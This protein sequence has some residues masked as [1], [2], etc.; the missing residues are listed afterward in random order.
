MNG[1]ARPRIG[2]KLTYVKATPHI[3]NA[4]EASPPPFGAPGGPR[5]QKRAWA[6]FWAL[7]PSLHYWAIWVHSDRAPQYLHNA[8]AFGVLSTI[9]EES[10]DPIS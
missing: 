6:L 5:A 1:V 8:G 10:L 2:L 7:G 3:G 4:L 9:I